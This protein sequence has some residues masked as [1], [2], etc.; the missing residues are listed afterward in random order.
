MTVARPGLTRREID[1]AG[2]YGNHHG[3][4]YPPCIAL[5]ARGGVPAPGSTHRSDCFPVQQ[6]FRRPVAKL[7]GRTARR[8][9]TGGGMARWRAAGGVHERFAGC[10]NAPDGILGTCG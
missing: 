6:T 4:R 5:P 10:C 8:A 1:S 3:G 2:D 7:R 9:A